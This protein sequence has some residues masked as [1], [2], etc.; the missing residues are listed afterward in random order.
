[1]PAYPRPAPPCKPEG[2]P[3]TL[4]ALSGSTAIVVLAILGFALV[5]GGLAGL[6]HC[7]REGYRIRGAGLPPAEVSA[8][9]RRLVT[10]NMA[11]V[12]AAA[13]GLAVLTAYFIMR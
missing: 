13:L 2:P 5:A 3:V 10:I 12:G 9:L 6:A 8:R 7:I 4:P 11:A 1:L